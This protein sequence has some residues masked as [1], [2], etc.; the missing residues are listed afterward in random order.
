MLISSVTLIVRAGGDT[1]LNPFATVLF[2]V[3]SAVTVKCGVCTLVTWVCLLLC[4]EDGSSPVSFAIIERRI[5]TCMR[6]PGLCMCLFFWDGDYVSQLPYVWYYVVVTGSFEHA[7]E[8]YQSKR[9]YM[10]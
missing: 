7:G 4:K 3:C 5:W 9:A 2:N 6:C 8:E 10:F 1:W